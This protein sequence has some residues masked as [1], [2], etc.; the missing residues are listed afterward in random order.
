VLVP[1]FPLDPQPKVNSVEVGKW[2]F[3]LAQCFLLL[4]ML[5]LGDDLG[6]AELLLGGFVDC[7]CGDFVVATQ[8]KL[9]PLVIGSIHQ[10]RLP[11]RFNL[12]VRLRSRI[13][14][15]CTC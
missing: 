5:G 4:M 11:A 15:G 10:N 2:W 6:G 3:Q 9:N 7:G 12:G 8:G 14:A 13:S 1:V